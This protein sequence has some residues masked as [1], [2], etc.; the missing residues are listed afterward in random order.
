MR[1]K[2][3][4]KRIILTG[5]GT[6]GHVAVN[7]ALIP[8]LLDQGYEIYYMGSKKGIEKDLIKPL[9]NVKYVAISTGKLR[10]Y[11]SWE[12]FKDIFRVLWGILQS[13]YFIFKINP[14]VIFSKGGFVSVPVLIGGWVNRKAQIA[15]ESDLTPGL[16]NKLVQ[17]FIKTIFTTFPDTEKYI[18]SGKAKFLG[19]V[20]RQ[21]LLDG[22][23]QRLKEKLKIEDDKKILLLMGGSLGAQALNKLLRENLDQ[24]LQDFNIIHSCGK[25]GLDPSIDKKGYY[26]FEYINEGLNDVL[27]ASDLVITR[28]GANAIFEFLYYKIPMLLIP[29]EY[30]SRGDQIDNA[31]SFTDMG[32]SL[33]RMESKLDKKSFFE[34]IYQVD[35]KRDDMKKKM[36]NYSFDDSIGKILKEINMQKR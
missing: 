15:H 10:R 18:K 28:A 14:N 30:G 36:S 1:N 2:K 21:D 13:I 4:D 31:K 6:T 35:S 3:I 17:P 23:K 24:L 12:N 27:A 16:A 29:F 26:Q 33:M 8:R 5:G 19:P 20:I 32:F 11:F 9:E 25:G 22:D 7:L 34:A